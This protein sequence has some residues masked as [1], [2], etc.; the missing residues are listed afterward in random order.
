MCWDYMVF[1]HYLATTEQ[2]ECDQTNL[3]SGSNKYLPTQ[4]GSLATGKVAHASCEEMLQ[5]GQRHGASPLGRRI[6]SALMDAEVLEHHRHSYE[7]RPF[8]GTFRTTFGP[9]FPWC[10]S[11]F[12]RPFIGAYIVDCLTG[13]QLITRGESRQPL[14]PVFGPTSG[15]LAVLTW[16]FFALSHSASQPA[17]RIL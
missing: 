13:P 4:V 3:S 17:H 9:A 5:A 2:Q 10:I 1:P 16:A 11:W 12:W 8:W 15:F 14:R 7:A 6:P